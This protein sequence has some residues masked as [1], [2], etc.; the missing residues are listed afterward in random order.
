MTE[1]SSGGRIIKADLCVIGAGAGGLTVAAGAAQMG[2]NTVLIEH[3][4]MG[5]DCLNF[6]CVPSKSLLAAAR[7]AHAIRRAGAFGIDAPAPAVDFAG[8]R[9]HV[10][11]VIAALAP[12]DSV[13][14]FEGLGVSVIGAPAHFV[15]PDMVAAGN[16]RVRAR[17]FVIATGSSPAVPPLPGLDGIP[18]LTNET[19]FEQLHRPEHLVV[20]GGGAVGLE[21]AQ[22]HARLGCRV[23][24]LESRAILGG[25]DPELVDVV[26]RRL[27]SEG[28]VIHERVQVRGAEARDGGV[29]L[30]T[31]IGGLLHHITG[32]HLLVATGRR[33]NVD[34]LGL[35]AA[36]IEASSRGIM[37][38]GRLR[39]SNKRVFAIGDVAGGRQF[40]HLA[41]HHA[42]I[43]LR[44][45]LF[46]LP[47]RS[48]DD[49][50]PRV[51]Y[52]APEL[53]SVGLSA[54]EAQER[55]GRIR[56]LRWPFAEND[57]AHAEGDL[58][59]LVKVIATARGRVLGAA[60]VGGSAGELILP[61]VFAVGGKLS[62]ADMAG[63][64]APYP[65]L[66][67]ASK[68]VAGTFYAPKLFSRATRRLVRFL[69][70]FG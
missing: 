68:R 60:I 63:V 52:T 69:S 28:I 41:S 57:R 36:G 30:A 16:A 29:S 8:V 34:G 49:A 40:T 11:G 64:I 48:R 65:T 43:V 9:A 10:H 55:H 46:R 45:A 59:G 39:T 50:V 67:E 19:I 42:G 12:N 44:N 17:R 56:V 61:W 66:S 26:R 37:V 32:S 5:G 20:L 1:T 33:A 58:D 35:E 25:D 14:R 24:I 23:T 62:L 31:E 27:Q 2:A 38:D 22:A 15:A 6:G 7:A 13:E 4:R 53:A 54:P 51:T 18:Y 47:A 70:W 21:M 3:G